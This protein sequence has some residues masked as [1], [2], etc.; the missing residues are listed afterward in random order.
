MEW[1]E[2]NRY[3]NIVEELQN[4]DPYEIL[5]IERTASKKEIKEA[6]YRKVKTYH[7]DNSDEFIKKNNESIMKIVN[8]AYDKIK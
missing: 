4:K 6:Y 3:S 5:E 8:D 7:P 2:L 1:K